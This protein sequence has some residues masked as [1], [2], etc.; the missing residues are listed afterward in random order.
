MKYQDFINSPVGTL[1]PLKG[2]DSRLQRAYDHWAFIPSLLPYELTLSNETHNLIAQASREIGRLQTALD[3][4]PN[5]MILQRTSLAREAQ[6]TSALEGTYAP[7]ES[8][9]EG[10]FLLD[11]EIS[12]EQR[13]VMNYIRAARVGLGSIENTP[14]RINLLS[15]LQSIIVEK[16]RGGQSDQGVVRTTP[17]IIGDDSKPVEESRFIPTPPGIELEAGFIA[18]EEWLGHDHSFASLVTI[19]LGHYQFETLHPYHD[20]NG[21]L[22]RLVISMQLKKFNL[23]TPP[24]LNLSAYFNARK[25]EYKDELL[26]VSKTG[27]FDRWIQFFA[28]AVITQS[29]SEISRIK[30]LQEL[31][32]EMESLIKSSDGRG[33]V[34]EIPKTL[35]GS[36]YFVIADLA[37]L[38]NKSYPA[39]KTAVEKLVALQ[40]VQEIIIKERKKIFV[41]P[42]VMRILQEDS[43]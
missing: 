39:V 10:E 22:G 15:H 25:E 13:E 17:V 5:P 7:L 27:N 16:T 21:R 18:W 36:P 1:V 29:Q 12:S 43:L 35:L 38:L 6:S 23:L 2:F 31:I 8:V 4:F 24:I 42:K 11:S 26:E 30:K 28:Q 40:I 3:T 14:I 33:L 41:S 9:F 37:K 19:A 20:G 34:L 32:G